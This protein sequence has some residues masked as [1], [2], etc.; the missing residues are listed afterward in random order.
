MLFAG[1]L[2]FCAIVTTTAFAVTERN[3]FRT[4]TGTG[5]NLVLDWAI[6]RRA[7]EVAVT[8]DL[9][10]EHYS[11]HVGAR[12]AVLCI[13]GDE[14]VFDVPAIHTD[15]NMKLSVTPLC[16]DAVVVPRAAGEV[17]EIPIRASWRFGG[18]YA[19][20]EIGELAIER[21]L[22]IDDTTVTVR[23]CAVRDVIVTTMPTETT[24]ADDAGPAYAQRWVFRSDNGTWLNL[25]LE[26]EAA[27]SLQ[28]PGMLDVR[29]AL[30]LEHYS[31]WMSEKTGTLTVAGEVIPFVAPA[32]AEGENLPHR[33]VLAQGEFAASADQ[34]IDF[35][36]QMPFHGVYS[37]KPLEAVFVAG[38][39][40]LG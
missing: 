7:G 16:R 24:A 15:E 21:T 36:A 18:V 25:I 26:V 37:G 12:R 3:W 13:G 2:A 6:E 23:E 8:V 11:L 14:A 39:V 35:S 20:R 22:V 38:S 40:T 5:L 33:V 4:D 1:L 10:L 29:Y 17:V 30:V 19:G 9:G 34:A 27:D 32:I 28:T 31:L